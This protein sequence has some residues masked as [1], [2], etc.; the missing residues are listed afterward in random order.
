[1]DS[2]KAKLKTFFKECQGDRIAIH[3]PD[4]DEERLLALGILQRMGCVWCNGY[5]LLQ[6]QCLCEG[7]TALYVS[8]GGYVTYS[9]RHYYYVELEGGGINA[10]SP[11]AFFREVKE[12]LAKRQSNNEK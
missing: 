1:M 5:D 4:S 6:Y 10:Y 7:C 2:Q 3:F 9:G 12:W 8:D 11:R